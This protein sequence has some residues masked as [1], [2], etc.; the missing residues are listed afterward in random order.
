LLRLFSNPLRDWELG[1]HGK[2]RIKPLLIEEVL[3]STT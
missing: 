1:V 3:L 2:S